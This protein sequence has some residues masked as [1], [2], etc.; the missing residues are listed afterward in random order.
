[1]KSW[2][3][4]AEI[5]FGIFAGYWIGKIM[6]TITYYSMFLLAGLYLSGSSGFS[7]QI[8]LW[9]L[10]AWGMILLGIVIAIILG[11]IGNGTLLTFLPLS[12]VIST[13][14]SVAMELYLILKII[15]EIM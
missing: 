8:F 2:R 4:F 1:M 14:I 9:T 13:V 12:G 15:L 3:K 11:I 5:F 10:M 6:Q 7:I